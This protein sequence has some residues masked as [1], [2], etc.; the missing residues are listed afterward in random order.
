[1]ATGGLRPGRV[2]LLL[3]DHDD[4]GAAAVARH[5]AASH[6]AEAVALLTGADVVFGRGLALRMG[7]GSDGAA[8]AMAHAVRIA[9]GE[10][11]AV[12]CR[13]HG[14]LAP[15]APR[16][17]PSDIAYAADEAAALM[18]AWLECLPCPVVNTPSSPGLAG[19]AFTNA[20]WLGLAARAGLPSMALRMTTNARAF[21]VE[22]WSQPPT[23]RP[24]HM[25]E[26]LAEPLFDAVVAGDRVHGPLTP[27]LHDAARRLAADA[28][29]GLL[30]LTFA[31]G[32]RGS[33][34]TEIDPAPALAA[35]GHAG[36][37]AAL[38]GRLAAAGK[39]Q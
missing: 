35:P 33:V 4:R 23:R 30:G 16:A 34:V 11:A 8:S 25:I 13:V 39:N 9:G 14:A 24:A 6:G 21:P 26:P 17:S 36:A 29:C 20:H 7:A 22:G 37:V 19:P 3:A 18:L 10:P 38:M 5:L 32:S 1:V 27:Q 2:F 15:W 28:G 12:L 31:R